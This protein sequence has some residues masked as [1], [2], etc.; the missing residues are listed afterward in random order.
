M[1]LLALSDNATVLLAVI[2]TVGLVLIAVINQRNGNKAVRGTDEVKQTL[3]TNNE[4]RN[5]RLDHQDRK[6]D[7]VLHQTNSLKDELVAEVRKASFA[8]GEKAESDKSK[9]DKTQAG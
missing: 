8:A 1:I 3:A 7:N 6:L 9:N 4:E 5:A 2:N